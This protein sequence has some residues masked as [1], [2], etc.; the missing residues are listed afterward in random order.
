MPVVLSNPLF[1][2]Q[3]GPNGSQAYV[4]QLNYRQM[5][6]E[7]CLWNPDLDPMMAGRFINNACEK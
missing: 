2:Y 3:V 1:P 6:S 4:Q 7:V 5:I